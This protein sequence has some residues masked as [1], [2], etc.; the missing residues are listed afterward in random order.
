V[1]EVSE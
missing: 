1:T